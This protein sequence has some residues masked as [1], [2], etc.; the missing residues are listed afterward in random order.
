VHHRDAASLD[1]QHCRQ[2]RLFEALLS[3]G[4]LDAILEEISN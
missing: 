2:Q 3:R 4:G 1:S